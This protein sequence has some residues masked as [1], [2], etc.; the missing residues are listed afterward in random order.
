MSRQSEQNVPH[1]KKKFNKFE[2]TLIYMA[3]FRTE[4][5]SNTAHKNS[6]Y[7]QKKILGRKI[8][9]EKS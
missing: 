4:Y 1:M 7:L 3:S 5:F 9:A 2:Q 6:I 8:E